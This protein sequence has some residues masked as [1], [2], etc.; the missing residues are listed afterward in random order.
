MPA[1]NFE[2][3]DYLK[4]GNKKQQQVYRIITENKVFDKLARFKPI[5]AGTIPIEIDTDESD[6]DII[7]YWIDQQEFK[8]TLAEFSKHHD[9]VLEEKLKKGYKTIIARF[10]IDNFQFEIFGQNRPTKE[11]EAYRH[12]IVEYRIIQQK[13]DK[14]KQQIIDLK[15]K[16]IKTE[17]AF[18]MLLGLGENPYLELLKMDTF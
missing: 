13:G 12:M 7:C 11:Q 15:R 18:G 6:L 16:G 3:L 17:P 10:K 2:K 4:L 9:Y 5:L 8:N 14:F 1:T